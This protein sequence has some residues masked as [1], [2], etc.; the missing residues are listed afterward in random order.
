M[1]RANQELNETEDRYLVRIH[2]A[3][4]KDPID[5]QSYVVCNAGA[6]EKR[7][8]VRLPGP[9]Q[10]FLLKLWVSSNHILTASEHPSHPAPLTES[11]GRLLRHVDDNFLETL[12]IA[13]PV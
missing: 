8:K 6:G 12:H 3:Q 1:R 9:N 4:V 7:R 5:L 2:D 13:D 10:L 11:H